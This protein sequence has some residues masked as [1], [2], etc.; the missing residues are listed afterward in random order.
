MNNVSTSRER[1][2][3]GSWNR[4]RAAKK[5]EEEEKQEN[6]EAAKEKEIRPRGSDRKKSENRAHAVARCRT[7]AKGSI[8]IATIATTLSVKTGGSKREQAGT[9]GT[10]SD[11]RKEKK[12]AGEFA[13][14]P[15][16]KAD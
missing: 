4:E 1:V 16:A 14:F 10:N 2:P 15:R 11:E 13:G 5:K 3:K 12:R 8:P 7:K 9:T 6:K